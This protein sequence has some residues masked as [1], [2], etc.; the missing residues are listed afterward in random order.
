MKSVPIVKWG[1]DHWSLLA[2]IECL[3]VDFKGVVSDN[4][5][6]NM[7]CNS[8]RHPGYGYWPMG[9]RKW[10]PAHGS[11]LKGYFDKNDPALRLG[12]H[13][14]W[15]CVEDFEAAGVLENH[16]TGMNPVFALT[17]LGQTLVAEL[18]RHKQNKGNFADFNPTTMPTKVAVLA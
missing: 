17:T 3:C 12:P 11:R 6:R 4:H 13:D 5:R 8:R 1:K 16:G 9:E 15:D 7:R 14:D 10:N 2:F 18:R